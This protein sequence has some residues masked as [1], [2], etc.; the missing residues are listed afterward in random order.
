VLGREFTVDAL[1]ALADEAP[2][3]I[4]TLLDPAIAAELLGAGDGHT[5]RFAHVLTRDVLY[6]ELPTAERQRLHARAAGTADAIDALAYHLRQAAPIGDPGEALRVTREAATRARSQLAYEHAAFQ[7][8]EA[9]GLARGDAVRAGLLLDLAWCEFRSG[10]VEDAWRSCRAAADLGRAAGDAAVVADAA[11]VLRGITNSPVTTEIHA[12]CREAL[13]MLRGADQVREAKVLAQLVVTADP[14][15]ARGE[16]DLGQRALRIAEA[17]GDPDARFL[18]MQARHTE[19]VDSRHVLARLSIGERALR[20]ADET[21]R[22]EYAA[23]GLTWRLDAFWELGRRLQLDA[24]LAA[25]AGVAGQLREPLWL[26]RLTM[27]QATLALFEG[28]FAQA[29]TL[30]DQAL[31]IGTRGGHEGAEFFHLVFRSHLGLQTGT[32]LEEVEAGVRRFVQTGPFLGRAWLALVLAGLGQLD[33]ASALWDTIVPHLAAFPREAP[34]WII[35]AVGNA[36]LCVALDDRETAADIYAALLPYADRQI[37]SG[38][39]TPSNGPASMY[40]GMLAAALDRDEAAETHLN[41]A[42]ASCKAMGAAPYEATTHLE[43]ARVLGRQPGRGAA[44]GAHLD[45]ALRLARRLGMAP[46]LTAAT[47]LRDTTRRSGALSAREQQ[48]AALIAEGLSNRQIAHR[49]HLS[50]RTAEN[51]VTHILTKLGF[52]SRARVAA[53]YAAR[54]HHD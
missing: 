1:G 24:E 15:A 10:A 11:T 14:F 34:E 47:A 4:L 35:A 50:E 36:Q 30:A 8:R 52:D 45:S 25:F 33:E 49:L 48:V 37:I 41:A 53:W 31:A 29:T 23:W 2:D 21:G 5:V 54:Q 27:M 46:L 17:T 38:A 28:R 13:A 26:W 9:L 18:A 6:A 39:H 3:R 32:G 22:H 43:L 12:M 40:L 7:Y 42:L 19:L 51:H 16:R 44:A 20:L